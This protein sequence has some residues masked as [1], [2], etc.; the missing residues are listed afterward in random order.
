MDLCGTSLSIYFHELYASLTLNLCFLFGRYSS[1]SFNAL[2]RK[3]YASK[4][5]MIRSCRKQSKTLDNQA[6]VIQNTPIMYT[7]FN[8]QL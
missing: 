1:I 2:M 6:I 3:P 5:A 8:F 7:F 4:L